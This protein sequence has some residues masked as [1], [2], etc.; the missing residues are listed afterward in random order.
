MAGQ[1][2]GDGKGTMTLARCPLCD[3]ERVQLNPVEAFILG[4]GTRRAFDD[5]KPIASQMCETHRPRVTMA[6][7]TMVQKLAE[8]GT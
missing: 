8:V 5:G 6:M 3:V 2:A 1:S 4:L 7:L